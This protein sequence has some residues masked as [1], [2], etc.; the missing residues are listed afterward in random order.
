MAYSL[1]YY[2]SVHFSSHSLVRYMLLELIPF[3]CQDCYF[4]IQ[5][6]FTEASSFTISLKAWFGI[7]SLEMI[8]WHWLLGLLGFFLLS[9]WREKAFLFYMWALSKRIRC[10]LF[11]LNTMGYQSRTYSFSAS[12]YLSQRRPNKTC[13]F[14]HWL[15]HLGL[16][17]CRRYLQI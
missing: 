9:F 14:A 11:V 17:L 8:N 10:K 6:R 2:I 4:K 3:P 1:S 16:I 7:L 13:T 12:R 5:I 15:S